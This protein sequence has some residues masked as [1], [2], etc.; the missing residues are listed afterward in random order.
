MT[1]LRSL[2]DAKGGK[3]VTRYIS[4]NL[5]DQEDTLLDTFRAQYTVNATGLDAREAAEDN[6]I[7]S[8]RSVL[9]RLVNNGTNFPTGHEALVVA[10][11]KKPDENDGIV[12][13]RTQG[14]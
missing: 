13:Y 4:G 6:T 10:Y 3:F 9:V 12:F 11:D 1:W 8:L 5:F 7:Y 2:V 14:R